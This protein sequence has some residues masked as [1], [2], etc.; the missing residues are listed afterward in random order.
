[1]RD[2]KVLR[3]GRKINVREEERVL[4]RDVL[5]PQVLPVFVP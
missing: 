5:R 3:K 2:A 1:M 4:R